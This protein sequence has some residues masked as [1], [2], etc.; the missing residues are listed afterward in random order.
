[1]SRFL[2]ERYGGTLLRH[3]PDEERFNPNRVLGDESN[4]REKWGLPQNKRL[5]MF[6][7]SPRS[8]KGLDT[9]ARALHRS[10][11]EG[12]EFV[13]VGPENEFVKPLKRIIPNRVHFLS[14]QPY[15]HTPELLTLADA[16]PI[17]SK[18]TKFARAQVPAKLLDAMAMARPIVASRIGDL[19][20]I[21]GG[22]DRGWLIDPDS[23]AALAD[24][25]QEIGDEPEKAEGRGQEARQWY[26]E[27]AST[28]AIADQLQDVLRVEAKY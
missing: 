23:P 7:G 19:P 4:L 13:L 8:H 3:G 25:L 5:A 24:A 10:E 16:V 27:N 28:T 22:G 17:P 20:E 14:P 2:K 26:I 6:I 11:S 21:L 1:M 9:I 15:H 12:W 18:N